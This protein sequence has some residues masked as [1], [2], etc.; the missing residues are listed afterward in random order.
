M[1]SALQ[2]IALAAP[3][4]EETERGALSLAAPYWAEIRRLT[5][6]LVTARV[7]ERGV[8]LRLACAVT[9]FRFGPARTAT[10]PGLV[11]CRFAIAGGLLAKEERG[12]LIFTQRLTVPPRLE[13]AVEDYVPMLSSHR[14]RLSAR[15][16]VYREVQE[17]AH[18]AIGQRYLERMARRT[19]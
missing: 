1:K 7:H 8:D 13:V 17:R 9:L 16:F 18:R 2:T 12:W 14:Q 3:V 4:V 11:E 5:V 6:G 19:R 10:T 15:H